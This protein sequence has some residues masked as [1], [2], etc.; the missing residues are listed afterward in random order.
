MDVGRV[1][2]AMRAW[3]ALQNG[4]RQLRLQTRLA[5]Y[6]VLLV[7]VLFALLIPAVLLIQESAILGT[8]RENGLQLVSIFAFS[9]VPA[10]VADD[11]LGLRQLVN[12]LE[13]ERDIRYAMILDLDGRVLLHT[14]LT[15]T[16]ALYRDP[17][18][19][20]ALAVNEPSLQ[21]THSPRGEILYD[22]AAPVLILNQRRAIARIGISVADELL[23]IRRTRNTILGLG[24]VSL[25]AGLIWAHLQA[26]RITRPIRALATAAGA[27]ARGDL[28]HRITSEEQDEVGHLADAFNRMA[29]SLRARFEV[30]RELSSTLNFQTVLE[31]LVRHARRL[32]GADVAFLAYRH[33]DASVAPVA[34]WAGAVGTAFRDWVIRPGQGH[35]GWVLREGRISA[36]PN[37]ATDADP[38]EAR[39][40]A[41]EGVLALILVPI[42]LKQHCVGVLGL[43][44][45]QGITFSEG[46]REMLQRLGDQAAV[47]LAN[48][49]AYREI[50]LLNL[51]LEA[52]VAERTRDLSQANAALEASHSKL[53]ALDRLKSDFVSNVSHELRTPLTAI[54][55]SVDN[56]LDGVA[57]E[58]SP[59]LQRY[60][61]KVR[62]NTDRLG[63]LIAD[64][65]D[66][67]RIEA[68]RVELR[69]APV[70]VGEIM[71]E[72]AESLRPMAGGKGVDLAVL[73]GVSP[74][75]AFV[76][77]DKLQ[78]VLINLT[79]N[80]VKFTPAGGTVA[81]SARVVDWCS[82]GSMDPSGPTH[83][84]ADPP[85]H[86]TTKVV[87]C[88]VEDT[89]EGIPPEELGA[90]FGKFHQVRRPGLQKAQGTG[91][92]LSI[93]KSLI[94][95]HGGRIW[96]ES[97]VGR[98]SRFV[99][100]LAAAEA[101]TL[102]KV[103][104]QAGL[105]P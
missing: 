28:E 59:T 86:V 103:E 16:G 29:D 84:P 90:I 85:S 63:R 18:T 53:Q 6:I 51:G 77:R 71:Q 23:L 73:P 15:E 66:L 36:P 1:G 79:E 82:C 74:A 5:L 42:R 68:G 64:L 87:E 21:E 46:T 52:K 39:V 38:H 83:R 104:G 33:G 8:A 55:M 3:H 19:L 4:Y 72:V 47:A 31:T 11:F 58:I 69:S 99:F 25:A 76:D 43:G 102:A 30:D 14:L 54:R 61:T 89:G 44:G 98:G 57:G 100:T 92:G 32:C 93:A 2:S 80:A 17:L 81:L 67:S 56:L 27:V 78:Q 37:P 95:L 94:E 70:P 22:F 35:A 88:T 13:R 7:T 75:I 96:V 50:E 62:N 60:L 48:A 105:R 49:L 91:L 65:L 97:Q 9:S 45:R 26:R 10:L 40:L 20:Y 101:R 12:S 24:V 34:A 41:E